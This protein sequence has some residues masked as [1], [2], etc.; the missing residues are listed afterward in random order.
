MP[1]SMQHWLTEAMFQTRTALD[2]IPDGTYIQT[3]NALPYTHADEFL[4]NFKGRGVVCTS[5]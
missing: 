2:T 4:G 5:G 3:P 1:G